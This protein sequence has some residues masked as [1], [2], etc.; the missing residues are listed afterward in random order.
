MRKMN[1]VFALTAVLALAFGCGAP[2]RTKTEAKSKREAKTTSTPV[3]AKAAPAKEAAARPKPVQPEAPTFKAWD[4]TKL[5]TDKWEGVRFPHNTKA[6]WPNGAAFTLW[7]TGIGPEFLS[8]D[9]NATDFTTIRI[10]LSAS[11]TSDGKNKQPVPIKGVTALWASEDEAK[12]KHPYVSPR[13]AS[14]QPNDP[15]NPTVWTAKIS[16]VKTWQGT[17]SRLGFGLDLPEKLKAGGDDR[18]NI[19]VKKIEFIK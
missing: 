13:S 9:A 4:F 5:E 3:P 18:Y 1:R 8:L 7:A 14:F 19:V 10:E 2:T 11:R 16:N 17:I 12:G 6:K 15:Q